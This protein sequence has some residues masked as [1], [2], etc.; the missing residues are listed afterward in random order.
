[1]TESLAKYLSN[2][3]IHKFQNKAYYK[4]KNYTS[5]YYIEDKVFDRLSEGTQDVMLEKNS[6]LASKPKGLMKWDVS[7]KKIL[8]SESKIRIYY[9]PFDV[10]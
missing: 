3:R 10:E 6:Q 9:Q 8:I 7:R 2:K 1:M 5:N 4:V